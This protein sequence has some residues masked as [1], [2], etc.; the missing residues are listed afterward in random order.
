MA[1]RTCSV[2]CTCCEVQA[3]T[4]TDM[5]EMRLASQWM[6]VDQQ[7][8]IYQIVVSLNGLVQLKGRSV[9]NFIPNLYLTITNWSL[10][11]K[12]LGEATQDSKWTV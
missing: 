9:S 3:E 4:G 7:V 12:P 2:V 10:L 5:E 6:V 1:L 11:L 8:V